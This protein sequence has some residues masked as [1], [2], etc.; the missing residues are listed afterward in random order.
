MTRR[1]R[2]R[3]HEMNDAAQIESQKFEAGNSYPKA[4]SP[5][6]VSGVL[7]AALS[8]SSGK[9]ESDQPALASS[10]RRPEHASRGGLERRRIEDVMQPQR[11][12]AAT[13]LFFGTYFLEEDILRCGETAA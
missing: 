1:F 4:F 6:N 8:D 11:N 10:R 5:R 2:T 12:G 7:R 3:E 9:A 13:V